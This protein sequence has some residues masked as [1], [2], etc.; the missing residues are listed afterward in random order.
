MSAQGLDS[1]ACCSETYK[2]AWFRRYCTAARVAS[3]LVG[4][5]ALPQPFCVEVRKKVIEMSCEDED[6]GRDSTDT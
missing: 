2:W 1:L 3:A 5:T 6:E 4:R